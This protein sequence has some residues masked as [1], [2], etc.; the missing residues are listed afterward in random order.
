[1]LGSIPLT[2]Y[3]NPDHVTVNDDMT[4]GLVK[5]IQILVF[6]LFHSSQCL[7]EKEKMMLEETL[8]ITP[9]CR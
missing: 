6:D 7:L 3:T 5:E 9:K 1:M 2:I 8:Q 4:V